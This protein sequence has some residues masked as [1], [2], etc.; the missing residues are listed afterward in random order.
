MAEGIEVLNA[1][2]IPTFSYPDAAVRAFESMWS[3]S[4]R[5]QGLYETPICGGRS[6]AVRARGGSKARELIERAA[7][8]GRTL[9]TEIES[10][11][12][13]ELYGI[14]TV[15]TRLAKD[16]DEAVVEARKLGFPV[17]LKVHS[18]IVTHKTDVGGVQLESDGRRASAASISDD[19]RLGCGQ[20][21]LQGFSWCDGSAH[22]TCRGLR[23]DSGK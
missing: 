20:G 2:G 3:Y 23:T 16:E 4:E 6:G 18:E 1:S 13:L 17:V 14:P 7:S 22:G 9:L 15:P 19:P 10:K 12:I 11:A 8:S 5:L 21:R